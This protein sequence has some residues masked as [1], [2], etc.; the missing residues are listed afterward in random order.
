MAEFKLGR[1]RFV[2]KGAWASGTVYYKDDIVRHGGRTYYCAVGHTA[3]TLFTTD[4]ATKW[5][6][7]TDGSAFLGD[8]VAG[9]Y[10]KQNDIVK[11]GGYIYIANTAHT[12]EVDGGTPGKLETDQAKWDLFADGFDWINIWTVATIY[13]VNDLVKYGG[14]VYLCNTAHT[15][16]ATFAADAD[17]LEADQ[18]KWD[19]F[20]KGIDW[21][22]DWAPATKY[23]V[24]DTVKYGGQLY[25][26]N[27]AHLSSANITLGLEADQSKWDYA[28]KGIEYKSVH[29]TNTR[30]KV[31]DVVKYGGGLWIAT[32]EHTSGGTNLA[33]DN[34]VSGVIATVGSISAAD[35][36]RTAGT[37]KD[38]NGSSGGSGTGQRF[39]II[40]DGTGAASITIVKGGEG[41]SATDVITVTDGDLG[42]GG[43]ASLTFQVATITQTTNWSQFVPG[44]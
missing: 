43:G 21:K 17:G 2:W 42:G 13:K 24:N 12:A 34:A 30:Y 41:H 32:R 40:I 11:Y 14:T 44:L 8:W 29:Q 1:I 18:S 33:S 16:S 19:V 4:E 23:R 10:Y 5:N 22:Q 28:H 27:E 20:A 36:S 3:S 7:F 9:T 31:N 39:N 37:Y 25:I 6:L 26:C 38:V 15:S 35:A